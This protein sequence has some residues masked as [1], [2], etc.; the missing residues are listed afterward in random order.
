MENTTRTTQYKIE[1]DARLNEL[2]KL[3]ASVLADKSAITLEIGCGHG[4]FLTAYSVAHPHTFCV[5]IDI[6]LDRVARADRKK[7][8]AEASNLVFVRAEAHEF[9]EA[10]PPNTRLTDVF[11]LF[12]DP[13]PKRRHHKNRII[14]PEF[15]S[16]LAK[17]ADKQARL[18]F[19]TDFAPYFEEARH[20]VAQHTDW[21]LQP[22]AAWPF[23]VT[24]VFQSRAISYQS[25]V[26]NKAIS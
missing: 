5:G 4:H 16:A 3:L 6:I 20:T 17:L 10:L 24:T 19:R 14:Q 21:K 18:C 11:I 12:P 22:E 7:G 13:W 2:R 25:L 9:L 23:E 26:A 8:R 15:L 1:R